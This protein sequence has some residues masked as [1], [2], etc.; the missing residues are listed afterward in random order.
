MQEGR[1]LLLSQSSGGSKRGYRAI[2]DV[3][4]YYEILGVSRNA[5]DGEIKRAF[6]K[7][8]ITY[9]PD[10]NNNP[11]AQDVFVAINEAYEVIGDPVQ[12]RAYD[13]R[14]DNALADFVIQPTP[15]PH[16]DPAYRK[17]RRPSP[18]HRPH[19]DT[20]YLMKDH[21]H[22]VYWFCWVGLI[23]SSLFLIDYVIPYKV[24]EDE[25]ASV[26]VVRGRRGGVAYI[27]SYTSQGSK[28]KSYPTESSPLYEGATIRWAKTRIYATPMWAELS[29]GTNRQQ[30]GHLY[31][32]LFFLPLILFITS[33]CGIV[34][35][36]RVELC[37]NMSIVSA[38]FIGISYIFL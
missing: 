29:D 13:V 8:A 37:F 31:G 38:I 16:R 11:D 24:S 26:R 7:L 23:L 14:L 32:P 35:R 34:F 28:I 36:T 12:R 2:R 6:R 20:Y 4:N 18:R 17:P 10:K 33:T 5:S 19:S 15:T 9:H 27:M 3:K 22:Y 30:L 25:I 21:L 1:Y